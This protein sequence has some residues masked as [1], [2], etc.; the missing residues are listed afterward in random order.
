MSTQQVVVYISDNCKSCERLIHQFEEWELDYTVKNISK[1]KA[2]F[3]E[4]QQKKVYGTPATFIDDERVLG[5]QKRK[6]KRTLGIRENDMRD[7]TAF[8]A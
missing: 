6:L 8:N 4:L 7:N 5:F 3:Q 1:D 2:Y